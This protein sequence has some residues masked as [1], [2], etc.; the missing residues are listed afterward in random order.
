[1]AT[2]THCKSSRLQ[3]NPKLTVPA[4]RGDIHADPT[5]GDWQSSLADAV[6]TPAELC[7]LLKLDPTLADEATAAAEEFPLLATRAYLSRIRPGDPSDPLLLQILPQAAETATKPGFVADPLSEVESLCGANALRKYHGR[8]LIVTSRACSVHCRYCFRRHFPY[9]KLSPDNRF[10]DFTGVF[11]EIAADTSLHE[12]VLS[13]GDPL[14]LP[15][16][17]LTQL[18]TRLATI[19]HLRRIRIHTR[20]PIMVPE[21]VTPALLSMLRRC[22]LSALVVVQVN[23]PAEIDESVA[24]SLGR[25][26]DSGV[27]VL[28]QSVLL[29][30]VNDRADVLVE[31]YER[32]ADLRVIPYYLHQLDMVAGAAHFEVPVP[33]GLALM[34]EIRAKLPGYAVPRYVRET[35][36]DTSKRLLEIGGGN[37]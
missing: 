32:L 10:S 36:H 18:L 25:L 16:E 37:P 11:N 34:A 17:Q 6:C 19:P 9:D 30:G 4:Q 35:Q 15:D 12:V 24:D 33:T 8:I 5:A 29:R 21:R 13:G 1:M 28:N 20:M 23:H 22:R 3:T 2:C 14:T 31:L 27:P 7:Q 26:V